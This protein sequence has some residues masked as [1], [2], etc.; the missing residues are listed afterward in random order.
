MI[1]D[2]LKVIQWGYGDVLIEP[3]LKKKCSLSQIVH[4]NGNET[5]EVTKSTELD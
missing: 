3:A 5:N 1:Y 2:V 4:E